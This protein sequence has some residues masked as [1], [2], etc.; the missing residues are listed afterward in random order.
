MTN[1]EELTTHRNDKNALEKLL[2]PPQSVTIIDKKVTPLSSPDKQ[3]T[4]SYENG[5]LI[6]I[7]NHKTYWEDLVKQ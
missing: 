2:Y 6:S 7:S 1:L 3:P 4:T 5:M